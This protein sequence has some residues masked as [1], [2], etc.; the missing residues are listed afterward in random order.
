MVACG[1]LFLRQREGPPQP[2][3]AGHL[4]RDTKFFVGYR[5]RVG[6]AARRFRNF[7]LGHRG[8]RTGVGHWNLG[9]VGHHPMKGAVTV[10]SDDSIG[11]AHLVPLGE[12]RLS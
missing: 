4:A 8:E 11:L 2:L 12:P 3:D 9:A 5:P 7:L 10:H 6:I 1:E